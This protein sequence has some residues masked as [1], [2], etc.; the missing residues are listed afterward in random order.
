MAD[1]DEVDTRGLK[2][3]LVE[4]YSDEDEEEE[5]KRKQGTLFSYTSVLFAVWKE[6][7]IAL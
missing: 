4:D 1:E 5:A 3:P 2:R 7:H 6:L